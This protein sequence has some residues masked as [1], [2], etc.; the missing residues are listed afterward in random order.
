MIFRGFFMLH[1]SGNFTHYM[2]KILLFLAGVWFCLLPINSQGSNPLILS[3]I[4]LELPN[5]LYGDYSVALE[6][7]MAKASSLSVRFGYLQ[8]FNHLFKKYNI[9]LKG[10][11]TGYDLSVEYRFFP[12]GKNRNQLIGFYAAPYVRYASLNLNFI[13]EI[14]ITPFSV[15][16]GYSNLGAGLQLGFQKQ[17]R[18]QKKPKNFL[19]HIICDFH[20]IGG[21]IDRHS[22]SMNYQEMKNPDEYNYGNIEDDIRGYVDQYPFLEKKLKFGYLNNKL[23]VSLPLVLPGLRAGFSVGYSF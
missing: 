6:R 17:L 3:N 8:P 14:Q 23:G 19:S 15:A 18:S 4:K 16:V 21:G 11:K 13:D 9:D 12:F 2:H 22:L 5:L 20:L 10:S 1:L 7:Q